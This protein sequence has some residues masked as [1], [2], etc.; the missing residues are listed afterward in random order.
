MNF[1]MKYTIQEFLKR[2]KN[3]HGN[4]YDYSQLPKYLH[5]VP[6]IQIYCKKHDNKFEQTI[7]K[8]LSGQTGCKNCISDKKKKQ[9]LSIDEFI[10]KAKKIHGDKYNYDKVV[11][12]NNHTK[13]KIRCKNGHGY[14]EKT[15]G[16]H[17][18]KTKPQGCRECSGKILWTKARFIKEAKKIHKNKY[19]YTKVDFIDSTK[20]VT[21]ICKEH[22]EFLQTPQKHINGQ[23][24]NKCSI[25]IVSNKNRLTKKEFIDKAI[26]KHGNLYKYSKVKYINN[27]TD[28]TIICVYHGEFNQNPSSHLSGSGCPLCRLSKGEQKVAAFLDKNNVKFTPQYKF[29]NSRL[30]FDFMF[31]R[32]GKNYLIEFNGAHH[33]QKV[34]YSK[35][36]SKSEQRYLYRVEKDKQKALLAKSKKFK[37]IIVN[38]E[39]T[40]FKELTKILN[41]K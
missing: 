9:N 2:A 3:I 25:E 10:Q 31:E 13:V 17:T 38:K 6:K 34:N 24:C 36:D 18:H 7:D 1:N 29:E 16:N 39:D 19:D 27:H 28:V 21:I 40:E 37:L 26:I 30:S 33:Y 8:H 11:Y 22:G 35:D 4:R 23:K 12:I 5:S 20:R 15:P 41:K 32:N 14:F